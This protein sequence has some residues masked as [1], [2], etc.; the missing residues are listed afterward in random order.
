M[1]KKL[2]TLTAAAALVAQV[3]AQ[4]VLTVQQPGSLA[5]T[6]TVTWVAP[7]DG[8]DLV[9]DP[10]DPAN[11]VTDTLVIVDDDS[12][13]DSLGC[14]D[15]VNG[16]EVNGQIAVIYRGA[17]EFGAKALN[18][19]E[20][21]ARA[22]LIVNNQPGAAVAM[23]AGAVGAQ[24]TIP[25][26]MIT[27]TDGAAFNAS[28]NS[29]VPVVAFLGS[30]I[31]LNQNDVGFFKEDVLRPTYAARPWPI[32]VDGSMFNFRIGLWL[33]GFG[34]QSQSNVTVTADVTQAGSS[35]FAVT[36]DPVAVGSGGDSVWVDLGTVALPSY[37]GFY[38]LTYTAEITGI[39]D[40][41]LS[42]NSYTTTFDVNNLI[43]YAPMDENTHLP[44][45]GG[46]VQPGD[47]QGDFGLC[48]HFQDPNASLI[49]A[50]GLYFSL[51]VGLTP[52]SIIGEFV[53]IDVH[54]WTDEFVGLSDAPAAPTLNNI[55]TG[56]Y[57][58]LEEIPG[59]L[60][61]HEF[62]GGVEL[63][64]NMRYLFCVTTPNQNLRLGY[65]TGVDYSLT[66]DTVDNVITCVMDGSSFFPGGFIGGGAA[67]ISI[68]TAPAGSIG[69][70]EAEQA[71]G[72]AFP[73]PASHELR[74]PLTA[75]SGAADLQVFNA[76]G[77][78]VSTQRTNATGSQLIVDVTSIAP[79]NYTFVVTPEK[80]APLSFKAVVSR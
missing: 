62:P 29:G 80:G 34:S 15:L 76:A 42:N 61:Y 16:A 53:Q 64:D 60:V 9:P 66:Q 36:S 68:L 26:A 59:Q 79:G 45:A 1:M 51:A 23:G 41:L 27:L 24:V 50:A 56:E 37:N 78:I 11:A 8:W 17:C 33:T 30:I 67:T 75:F 63:Q 65:N 38:T 22:V 21:G 5:G 32:S 2:F 28:I 20:A 47:P 35:V 18:A 40:E 73:N 6:Y 39:T 77:A 55:Y 43:G 3:S 46:H 48:V 54:E 25:V 12:G 31:N 14:A 57:T 49:D 19:Q 4:V 71:T 58:F 13:A 44:V 69:V 70:D 74:I 72:T 10:L 7:A 52:Q